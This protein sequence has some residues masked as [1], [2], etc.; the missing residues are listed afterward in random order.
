MSPAHLKLQLG[1][2]LSSSPSGVGLSIPEPAAGPGVLTWP[3][4]S[5]H[6]GPHSPRKEE[7]PTET[8]V[9]TG[10]EWGQDTEP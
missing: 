10:G 1:F 9:N 7:L 2:S 6:A 4:A 5:A 3:W 8:E